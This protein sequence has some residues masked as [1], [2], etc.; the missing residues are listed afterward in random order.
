MLK[1]FVIAR[2]QSA[3]HLLTMLVVIS[4]Y[5]QNNIGIRNYCSWLTIK[6]RPCIALLTF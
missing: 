3:G 2:D 1:Q 6:S 5:L 4:V